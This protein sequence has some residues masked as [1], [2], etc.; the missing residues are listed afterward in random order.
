[1][2]VLVKISLGSVPAYHARR[3]GADQ[4][5]IVQDERRVT[6]GELERNANRRAW[7]L[8]DAGVGVDDLVTVALPNGPELF[9]TTF[10]IWKLGATPHNVSWRLPYN[11]FSAIVDLAKPRAI[12]ASDPVLKERLGARN[13]HTDLMS[14][15]DDAPA[16]AR[17]T[18]WRAVS[19]GGSTGRPKIVVSHG[20]SVTD[21]DIPEFGMPK[22]EAILNPGPLYHA[23]PFG[24]AHFAL[25]AGN[26]LI[27][28]NRFDAEEAL[29]LIDEHRVS[30]VNLVPT[31]MH[32]IWRLPAEVRA[33]YDVSSLK[34]VWHMAS[35]MPPWLKAAWIDWLGPERIFEG[36]GG[37]EC[38]GGTRITGA[39]WLTHR[40]SVG[41]ALNCDIRILDEDGVDVPAGE[42][43]EIY[44]LPSDGQGSTYHYLGSA[45][46]E[47]AGG[48]ESIGDFG[49]LDA[50]GYL[51]IADRR[52][53]MITSGGANVY[54]AEV[55]AALLRHPDID[56]AVV[57]GLP[58]ED[59]GSSVHAII[60][61]A[62]SAERLTGEALTAFLSEQLVAYKW[63]RSFELTTEPLR[64]DAGKVRRSQL[65]EARVRSGMKWGGAAGR[66]TMERLIF[67]D[68]DP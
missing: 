15:R 19:S 23:A 50:E 66:Q 34:A 16:E 30:W 68:A 48:Y 25:F 1:L 57:I 24:I 27:N 17:A 20:A 47:V 7:A 60:S 31:M 35:P 40:G 49:W 33:R 39:E 14:D 45:V 64:D 32:R 51:Y 29:R 11:E 56:S 37:S 18:Y 10:A 9:E 28:M 65:R 63:P 4:V 2:E 52:V 53:D 22:D 6:W 55:E 62:G 41:R 21:P 13:P 8:K 12:I 44:F 67:Q 26:T 58:H 61:P 36:Y 46:R 54:P 5:A 43:G 3:R 42:V 59:F 38:Q